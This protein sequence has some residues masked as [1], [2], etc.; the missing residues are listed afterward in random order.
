LIR[1]IKPDD[2]GLT[3]DQPQW[4]MLIA[5][6]IGATKDFCDTSRQDGSVK[7]PVGFCEVVS[8][9]LRLRRLVSKEI[10]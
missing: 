10:M 1:P 8:G 3:V 2:T 9:E 6:R 5:A 7:L 4:A